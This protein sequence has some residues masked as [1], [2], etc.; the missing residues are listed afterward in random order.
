MGRHRRENPRGSPTGRKLPGDV[1]AERVHG[2]RGMHKEH[3]EKGASHTTIHKP[4]PS[5]AKL[6]DDE[7]QILWLLFTRHKFSHP[8]LAW[9]DLLMELELIEIPEEAADAFM[10]A[11]RDRV[12]P[13]LICR[14]GFGAH[15]DRRHIDAIESALR[16]FL[17][18]R[19]M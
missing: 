11:L 17:E 3:R 18:S 5:K 1:L 14:S 9:E 2:R 7:F 15:L 10:A 16:S 4:E 12:D 6:S 19:K 8:G 13:W